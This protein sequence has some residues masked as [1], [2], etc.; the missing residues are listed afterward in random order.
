MPSQAVEGPGPL[1]L[2][3]QRRAKA[4]GASPLLWSPVTV[5]R[6]AAATAGGGLVVV[7]SWYA[8]SGKASWDE[9]RLPLSLGIASL[10]VASFACLSLLLAGRRAIGL[11]RVAL[12]GDLPV[13]PVR[14]QR[15]AEAVNSSPSATSDRLVGAD[16]LVRYHRDDCA[17]VSGRCYPEARR[18][19]HHA[20]GRLPCGVCQP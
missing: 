14:A 9:Q 7:G 4:A 8:V 19:Q 20:V 15:T 16:G 5:T 17:L 11:R 12:L 10:V 1:L 2:A 6:W 3:V 18:A 13:S